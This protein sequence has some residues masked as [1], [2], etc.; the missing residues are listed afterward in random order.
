MKERL[1]LPGILGICSECSSMYFSCLILNQ[2]L[3]QLNFGHVLSSSISLPLPL[4][5]FFFSLPLSFSSSS[6]SLF[7]KIRV[8]CFEVFFLVTITNSSLIVQMDLRKKKNSLHLKVSKNSSSTRPSHA[9][10]LVTWW[11]HFLSFFSLSSSLFL[12]LFLSDSV[13]PS[14]FFSL[15]LEFWCHVCT[16][17]FFLQKTVKSKKSTFN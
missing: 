5:F 6:L 12:S 13:F 7:L 17:L 4:S 8:K 11:F 9:F 1:N 15:L 14:V 10:T 3:W 16:E 2:L